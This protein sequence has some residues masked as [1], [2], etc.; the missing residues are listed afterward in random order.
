[1]Y[2]DKLKKK[3]AESKRKFT[4]TMVLNPACDNPCYFKSKIKRS[5]FLKDETKLKPVFNS[6]VWSTC[7]IAVHDSQVRGPFSTLFVSCIE[8]F[9]K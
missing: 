1:M 6:A 2:L 4:F 9:L 5:N 7:W 3:V 8:N